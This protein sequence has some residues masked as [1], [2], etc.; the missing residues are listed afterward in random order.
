MK[1]THQQLCDMWSLTRVGSLSPL[2][3]WILRIKRSRSWKLLRTHSCVQGSTDCI[4]CSGGL[5]YL[6]APPAREKCRACCFDKIYTRIQAF[7]TV[8]HKIF[9]QFYSPQKNDCAV[10]KMH[11]DVCKE[12]FYALI[13]S[14]LLYIQ[15]P[16]GHFTLQYLQRVQCQHTNSQFN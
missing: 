9:L 15:I 13:Q 3:Q 4:V 8:N 11:P 1:E 10:L 6:Q 2:G 12:H 16:V 7:F 14:A 5:K